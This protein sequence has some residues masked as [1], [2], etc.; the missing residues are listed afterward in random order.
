MPVLIFIDKVE[1]LLPEQFVSDTK[2]VALCT[3]S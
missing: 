3:L 1:W 2:L